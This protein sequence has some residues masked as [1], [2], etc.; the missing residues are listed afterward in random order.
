V[1][2]LSTLAAVRWRVAMR[3]GGRRWLVAVVLPALTLLSAATSVVVFFG[4]RVVQRAE[5]RLVAPLLS[6]AATA[7]GLIWV[8]SP[9][10][11]GSAASG[12]P[13]LARL[14]HFPISP[15]S[16]VAS[17][18]LTRLLQP[19]V[20]VLVPPAIVLGLALVGPTAVLL[21]VLVALL[22]VLALVVASGELVGILLHALSRRRR[23]RD[24]V[25]LAGVALGLLLGFVPLILLGGGAA[26]LV[27]GVRELLARDVFAL[28][29]FAWGA[30][31]AVH[32]ARGEADAYV[33]SLGA[34]AL[35]L[36]GALALSTTLVQR[37][38][39]GE[40]D[41]GRD[42]TTDGVSSRAP[43]PGPVGAIIEKDLRMAWRDPRHRTIVL[44]GAATPLALLVLL[45]LG[46]A[47]RVTPGP[48]L[49]A[50]SLLGVS[51]LGSNAL[52]LERRGVARLL[53]F[54]VDRFS[55]F[56]AKNTSALLLRTPAVMVIGAATTLLV[57]LRFVPAVLGVLWLTQLLA[58]AAENHLAVLLPLAV[59]A[60]GRH[61]PAPGWAACGLVVAAATVVATA[62]AVAVSL[63]FAFLIWLPHLLGEHRLWI[64]TLPLALAGAVAVYGLVTEAAAALLARRE[65]D[66]VAR[67]LDEE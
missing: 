39:R 29:P 19:T 7:L 51:T 37:M 6:A 12:G 20:L 41:L 14:V 27:R 50:A 1:D 16:L 45:W 61:R 21:P 4:I 42:E 47:G 66:L 63:P 32:A 59:R 24:R 26:P 2:R 18:L 33:A 46:S 8:F 36:A 23:L 22:L 40:L 56:V 13:D 9:L 38:Y 17:S 48:L 49:V 11:R 25:L 3:S 65:P 5:P 58:A 52:A 44:T 57:G 35:A 43:L 67:L 31:A 64:L 15:P 54:P 62:V 34:A 28:S 10:L 55:I 30:R 60:P 53:G